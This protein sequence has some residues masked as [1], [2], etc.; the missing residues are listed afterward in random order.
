MFVPFDFSF[1][2]MKFRR[3]RIFPDVSY[4]YFYNLSRLSIKFSS[5]FI[6]KTKGSNLFSKWNEI[7]KSSYN[8]PICKTLILNFII[9]L[10][11]WNGMHCWSAIQISILINTS[12]LRGEVDGRLKAH[13]PYAVQTLREIFTLL[14]K[15]CF[16]CA[17]KIIEL[18]GGGFTSF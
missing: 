9:Y 1:P 7:Y 4:Y 11:H 6:Y 14:R 10:Q 16:S 12:P 5:F 18:N 3:A 13:P 15:W 2:S 17:R 8:K